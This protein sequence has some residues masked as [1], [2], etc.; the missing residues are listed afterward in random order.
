MSLEKFN[1]L[2]N[3]NDRNI[4][5][6]TKNK[7]R[8]DAETYSYEEAKNFKQIAWW[9]H[10]NYVV[11]D[12]DIK[13]HANK[14]FKMVK[15]LKLNC[16][17]FRSIKGAH[18]VFREKQNFPVPQVTTTY[19]SV[20]LKFDT[21]TTNKGYIVLPHKQND[22]KWIKLCTNKLDE[23]PMWL[24]PQKT[25]TNKYKDSIVSEGGKKQKIDIM[26]DWVHMGESDGRNDSLFR[27]FTTLLKAG[28]NLTI[29]EKRESIRLLNK[30]VLKQSL[31]D[32]ELEATVIREEL[33]E[34]L[35]GDEIDHGQE[36][37]A[38][39][40]AN[41]ILADEDIITKNEELFIY[42]D[43]YYRPYNEN[44]LHYLI[45]H[46]YDKKAK[47]FKRN[48]IVKFVRVKT[49]IRNDELNKHPLMLNCV[50]T[51]VNLQTLEE[52]EHTETTY[53]T[54]QVPH[55]YNL[56]AKP[57]N[58]LK[59]FLRFISNSN[60]NKLTLI[61]EMIGLCLVKQI[62][63]EKFFILVGEKGANGKS[64]LLEII[65]NLL[66]SENVSNI[67][68]G[69]IGTDEYA[70]AELY[71]KLANI[72]DDL[73]LSALKETG[74][75][76]TLTSGKS[77]QAK[78]KFKPRF[79][80]RSFA[81]MI[82][83]ANKIPITYDKTRGFYRRFEIIEFNKT[84]PVNK[85]DPF[86]VDK[87]TEQDYQYLLKVS[88]KAVANVI[89]RNSLTQLSES[90]D[91]MEKYKTQNSSILSFL[92]ESAIG[93]DEIHGHGVRDLYAAYK[94]YCDDGGYKKL[95]KSIF[96]SEISSLFD[97]DKKI[98]SLGGKANKTRWVIKD[99]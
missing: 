78:V 96:D 45:H 74:L 55:K 25:L 61:Y 21:R 67:D 11:I 63:I 93:I 22:R 31:P 40:I 36:L 47:D 54:I 38:D 49:D 39:I 81:T 90:Q 1:K 41:K 86:L 64:T 7:V 20:G 94:D 53:D 26:P 5:V 85:R 13:S 65:E 14:L 4:Y 72:G 66:G 69:E 56:E 75:I 17:V 77:I 28:K 50:N 51:R 34:N 18:F 35:K 79:K 48:E 27:Y 59:N 43:G 88:I 95:Q 99:E 91:A 9:V 57:S 58:T 6:R 46:K 8:C 29:D 70:A 97:V 24:Y 33:T 87:L 84:V 89:A 30:Y 60:K 68:L 44:E 62:V 10:D 76:K 98:T 19:S 92:Q 52:E 15:D 42:E 80:F 83:A 82:Y 37:D 32:S 23:L 2:I 73:K 3:S 16:H 71:G 12:V